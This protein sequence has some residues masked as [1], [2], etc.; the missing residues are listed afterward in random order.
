[1]TQKDLIVT[2]TKFSFQNSRFNIG[3]KG[4][5]SVF[6]LPFVFTLL[7]AGISPAFAQTKKADSVG[8]LR[9]LISKSLPD[10]GRMQ[11]MSLLANRYLDLYSEKEPNLDSAA[12]Y[13]RRAIDLSE[14][15]HNLE[16]K[17]RLTVSMGSYYFE[18]KQPDSGRVRIRQAINYYQHTG[19]KRREAATWST[20][21]DHLWDSGIKGYKQERLFCCRQALTLYLSI[22][23]QF[24][25]LE[26]HIWPIRDYMQ[27]LKY[28]QAEKECLLMREG[29]RKMKY[30]GEGFGW[31]QNMLVDIA[32]EKSDIY[33]QLFYELENLDFLTKHPENATVFAQEACYFHLSEIYF[34]LGNYNKSE[35]Y[36][37][38]QFPLVF[39]LRGDYK[40]GLNFLIRSILNQGR[41]RDAL[42]LLRAITREHAPDKVQAI[43][44]NKLYGYIYAVLKQNAIAES[45]FL[46]AVACYNDADPGHK[47]LDLLASLYLP[48]AEFYTA[49]QLNRK[50]LPYISKLENIEFSLSPVYKSKVSLMRSRADSASGSYLSALNNFQLYNKTK[51][52]IF[53]KEKTAQVNQLEVSFDTR[54]KQSKIELLS[55]Q[56]K[57]HLAEAQ[58]AQ[59]ERDITIE[60]IVVVLVILGLILNSFSN[61]TKSN[62]LLKLKKEEIDQQNLVLQLLLVEK[63]GL[64]NDK[65]MLLREVHHRVKNNLQIVMS[66]LST[67]LEFL[68]NKDAVKAL[69][70]SQQRVYSI[71][72]VHQK[73]YRGS[74]A[75]SIEMRSYIEDMVGNLDSS[76]GAAGRG[77]RFEK[78]IG[79][80]QLDIDQAI[81]LGLILNE[82]ITN[83]IKYA[84]D[85]R[86]G[87]VTIAME[88]TGGKLLLTIT[89]NGRGLP[90]D[91][92][93]ERSN[94][95]GLEMMKGLARQLRGEIAITNLTGVTITLEFPIALN[96]FHPSGNVYQA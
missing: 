61:K 44:V 52:S 12:W 80:V 11:L 81:P 6:A 70:D 3:K 25:A 68:D 64:L 2:F 90:D 55:A 71:A 15:L 84:F 51:D 95:L 94:S 67:Q 35:F 76:F 5:I 78:M 40:F 62:N 1:M 93:L 19:N 63:D 33:K 34:G 26:L 87:T 59:Q 85:D 91:F 86:G 88:Y 8:I 58:R 41:P 66:L 9:A 49:V 69:E 18:A 92:D 43:T 82:A 36:A 31:V 50:A 53:N 72:L 13:L 10:S 27:E 65:D 32:V 21:A 45:Y 37:R 38:K 30:Y 79:D 7:L 83:A 89:D 17:N 46:Q 73:L 77:V 47:Q 75:V 23:D 4:F 14:H 39:K 22:G 24:H 42:L 16:W 74:G 57:I 54:Q 20:L 96:R 48:V 28:D 60:G 29:F 56:S